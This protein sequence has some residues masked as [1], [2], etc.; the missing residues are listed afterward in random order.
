M[1][2]KMIMWI[3]VVVQMFTIQYKQYIENRDLIA[4]LI[5]WEN[6]WQGEEAMLLT[7]SVALNRVSDPDY[8]DSIHEVVYQ[9]GQYSTTKYFF[10]EKLPDEC[11][12]IADRLLKEGSIAPS[13]VVFQAMF[14]QGSGVY[15]KIGTD[16]FCFK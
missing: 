10:S 4:E 12:E 9:K 16:Y 14:K 15:K 8:P 6:Y 1:V 11:Y 7:G 2:E 5:Y 13:N 3:M